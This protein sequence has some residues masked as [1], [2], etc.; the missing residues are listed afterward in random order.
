MCWA[1]ATPMGPNNTMCYACVHNLQNVYNN[2]LLLLF[3]LY[4]FCCS[5]FACLCNMSLLPFSKSRFPPL[6]MRIESPSSFFHVT[7]G[8]GFPVARH[9]NAASS[10]SCTAISTDDSSLIIS[11]G[12]AGTYNI[13][14][15]HTNILYNVTGTRKQ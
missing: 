11:G 10:P 9:V 2:L 8:V 7:L 5:C 15:I 14:L 6:R 4:F 13:L 1:N 3:L 12:T